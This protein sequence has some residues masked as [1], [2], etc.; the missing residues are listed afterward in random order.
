[1]LGSMTPS[2]DRRR[3]AAR[4]EKEMDSDYDEAVA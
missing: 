4:S 3:G 1:V 2:G